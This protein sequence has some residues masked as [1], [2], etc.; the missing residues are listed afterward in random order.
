MRI[1]FD[2]MGPRIFHDSQ[3]DPKAERGPPRVNATYG[4]IVIWSQS[5]R[6]GGR[7]GGAVNKIFL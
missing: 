4:R 3:V 2:F 1:G 7:E 5:Q 6:G